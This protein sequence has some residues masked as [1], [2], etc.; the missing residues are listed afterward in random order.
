MSKQRQT[1]VLVTVVAAVAEFA[2]WRLRPHGL[3]GANPPDAAIVWA[4]RWL[5]CGVAGYL[6]FAFA[7]AALVAAPGGDVR[8]PRLA[9]CTPALVRRVVHAALSVGLVS[10]IAAPAPAL[11]RSH[12]GADP[13]DWPGLGTGASRS[14]PTRHHP[15]RPRRPGSAAHPVVVRPGDSLWAIAARRLGG[16]ASPATI[17]ENWPRWYAANRALIGPDP[18]LIHPGQQLRPPAD[19]GRQPR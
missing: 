18:D 12:R 10:A 13:L 14:Q 9:R 4:C 11:A 6:G 19:D 7:V 3:P 5:G 17:A 1:Q 16:S 8:A 2:A 15:T